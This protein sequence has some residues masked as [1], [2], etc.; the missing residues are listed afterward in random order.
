[1]SRFML[2]DSCTQFAY[3]LRK[4]ELLGS[5]AISIGLES[6]GKDRYYA[7]KGQ[8]ICECCGAGMNQSACHCKICGDV[9]EWKEVK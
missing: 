4:S 1:M 5:G 2:I 7:E 9:T 3:L 6:Y 8:K